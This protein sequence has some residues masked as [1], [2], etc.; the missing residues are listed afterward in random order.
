MWVGE[1][2]FDYID[3]KDSSFVYTSDQALLTAAD[4]K[5]SLNIEHKLS[6]LGNDGGVVAEVTIK[7]KGATQ[8]VKL[9]QAVP[10]SPH[11]HTHTRKTPRT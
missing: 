2:V 6:G 10:P 5:M 3:E 4:G 7:G 8:Q 9:C 11:A 1:A